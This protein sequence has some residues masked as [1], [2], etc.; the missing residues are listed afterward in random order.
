MQAL[1]M[2]ETKGALAAVEAA[3]VMLKAADVALV[4][5]NVI[6]GGLVTVTVTGDV[7]AV[8]AAVEAGASAVNRLGDSFLVTEHVIARPHEQIEDL[9]GP[10]KEPDSKAEVKAAEHLETM[11]Q[12]EMVTRQWCD[13][14]Y[15]ASGTE[16]VMEALENLQVVQLRK[17]ARSYPELGTSGRELSRA[18]RS[19]LLEKLRAWY[20]GK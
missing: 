9:L 13:R 17:L 2:I 16:A 5:K 10:E 20:E 7:A 18:N 3:D 19:G 8:K 11:E 14:L 15:E 1:G 12:P 6:G 4:E